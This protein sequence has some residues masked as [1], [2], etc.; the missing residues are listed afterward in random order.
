MS[1]ILD[2]VLLFALPASGKSE[3]RKYMANLTP[4]QCRNDFRMGL[5]V[6]LDDFPYV[7]VMRCIDEELQKRSQTRLYFNSSDRPFIDPRDWGTL[8]QLINEDYADLLAHKTYQPKSAASH[9]FDR[10]ENA[11]GKVGFS[12]RI[13]KLDST[14]RGAIADVLEKECRALLEEKNQ[15]SMTDLTGKTIIIEAA[16]GGKHGS[17]MPLPSPFGYAYSVPQLSDAILSKARILYV[18]VT[19][20]ESRRKN[21]ERANPNDPGSILH[22]G[23]PIE[24]MMNDYGCDDMDWLEKNSTKPGTISIQAH[25]KSY[26]VPIARF[27][28]RSDKTTF[29]RKERSQWQT[30]EVKSL[31]DGL[32]GAL[33]RLADFKA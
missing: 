29:V 17:S 24:V 20:E 32:S 18:W 28:N 22:H 26:Q 23:V 11:A 13:S 4:E 33:T 30:D 9:L 15:N 7:H 12:G 5:T 1:G 31:H 25:Q 10:L 2:T 3:V 6:Q 16:R 14:V 27:D 21:Q 19:P 8:M